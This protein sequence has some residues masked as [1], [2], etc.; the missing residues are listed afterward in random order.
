M[1]E[2]RIA[3][4]WSESELNERL[5]EARSLERN[6]S[7]PFDEM[8]L[9]RGW[10]QY[11]SEALVGRERAGLPEEDGPFRRGSKAVEN[12]AFSDPKIVL[13]H[14]KR[15]EPLLGR[16]M[17]LEMR[18]LRLLRYLAGVV[19]GEVQDRE[20]VGESVFGFRY[21]TLEGHIER[22]AEWFLLS[23]EHETGEIRFR[24]RATWRPGD[25]PNWWSRA[26]FNWLGPRYQEKWH[27][28]A[29]GLLARLIAAP[30]S[31][32]LEPGG[33]RLAHTDPEVIFRRFGG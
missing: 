7:E 28:R 24:I 26:G 15:G 3:T 8:S 11:Y 19:V 33:A 2:Y 21:D 4:G 30:E 32:L 23:K 10:R 5:E 13:G 17:L 1:A 25:F 27:R 12:Y 31:A 18:A 16:R 29:H 6:F 20:A 14:F 9:E 22:G